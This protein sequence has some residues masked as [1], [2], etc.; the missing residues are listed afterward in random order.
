MSK[1]AT[2]L[3]MEGWITAVWY[4]VTLAER[5]EK[6][7]GGITV[8]GRGSSLKCYIT[9]RDGCSTGLFTRLSVI[10]C[11]HSG[12]ACSAE[13]QITGSQRWKQKMCVFPVRGEKRT[14]S[15]CES[16]PHW[17]H[18]FYFH[19]TSP[20]KCLAFAFIHQQWRAVWEI[21]SGGN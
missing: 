21:V 17:P 9:V 14:N 4:S 19:N 8:G 6:A 15:E 13:D 12:L 16:S 10:V 20:Q 2:P 3:P 7:M 11:I 18:L 5:E 1:L